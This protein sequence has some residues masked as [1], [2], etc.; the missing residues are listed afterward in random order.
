[1]ID[2]PSR[3]STL[4]PPAPVAGSTVWVVLYDVVDDIRFLAHHDE[5]KMLQRGLARAEWPV[6]F[7]QGH[8]P[9]P[10][11][12]IPLPR[13]LGVAA[14]GQ[15]AVVELRPDADAANLAE[16]LSASLP[17][18]V[19]LRHAGP[20]IG[21]HRPQPRSVEYCVT[22]EE[23]DVSDL[24][25]IIQALMSNK[26]LVI[27]R[28]MG[29]DKPARQ[30]DIRGFLRELNVRDGRLH[31][32]LSVENQASAR[33]AEVLAVLGLVSDWYKASAV[34]MWVE[35]DPPVAVKVHENKTELI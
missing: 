7:S 24:P 31:M 4:A 15:L 25:E 19:P 20:L 11:V 16:R 28:E 6:R 33:P 32:N 35:W 22:L 18:Q 12:T 9:G 13:N 21:G 14:L 8:N 26:Q 10:R 27:E 3:Q 17:R 1:M 30:V 34:R 23:A 2:V 5:M 29:P